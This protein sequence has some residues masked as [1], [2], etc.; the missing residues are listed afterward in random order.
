MAKEQ[1]AKILNE[2]APDDRTAAPGRAAGDRD[3]AAPARSSRPR[4][5]RSPSTLLGYPED[6]I[7]RLMTPDYV[8][9]P[10]RLDGARRARP[11]PAHGHDSET[12]N[13]LYVI[14]ERSA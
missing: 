1:V 12:L 7:G 8:A 13:V 9:R 4:S 3:P 10:A 2:M 5:G 11:H 6:S 14:D